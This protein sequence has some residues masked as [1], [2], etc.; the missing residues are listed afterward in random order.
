MANQIGEFTSKREKRLWVWIFFVWVTISA[1]LFVGRPFAHQLRSQDV[2]AI[3]FLMAMILAAVAVCVHGIRTKPSK[4]EFTL[5]IGLAT[6]YLMLFFRLGAPERSHL[7]EYSVL[8]IFLHMAL[9]ERAKHR[10]LPLSPVLLSWLMASFLGILDESIQYVIPNR[11]FDP[12]DIVFNVMAVSMAL[13]SSLLLRWG[14]R[15]WEN[16]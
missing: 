1:S 15:R 5:L 2:Q 4:W 6:I 14:R 13:G 12:E 3:F 16:R 8:A 9:L 10:R 7:I 11:V